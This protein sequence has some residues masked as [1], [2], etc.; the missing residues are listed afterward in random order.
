MLK[1][2]TD[3][4]PN[5]NWQ[6]L[7][8]LGYAWLRISADFPDGAKKVSAIANRLL[9]LAPERWETVEFLAF[10]NLARHESCLLY[11]SDAADEGL[12]VDLGGRRII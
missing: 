7:T 3:Q 8:K 2:L 10:V 1:Q 6:T 11:T 4:D 12:G 5:L 9:Q